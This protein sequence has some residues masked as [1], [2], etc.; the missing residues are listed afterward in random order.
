MLPE[1][2]MITEQK[3]RTRCPNSTPLR[4]W[5]EEGLSKVVLYMYVKFASDIVRASFLDLR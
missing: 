4:I 2:C 5:A 1:M 3:A